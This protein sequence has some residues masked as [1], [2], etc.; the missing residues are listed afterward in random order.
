MKAHLERE[1]A[2]AARPVVKGVAYALYF[3]GV[4]AIFICLRLPV[5]AVQEATER[6]LHQ[7]LP[8]FSWR[9]A[10]VAVRL[11]LTFVLVGVEASA[12]GQDAP[13]FK[14]DRLALTPA[15]MPLFTGAY[16]LDYQAT[17]GQGTLSGTV[18]LPERSTNVVAVSGEFADML[19]SSGDRP[20]T[21]LGREVA[22]RVKGRF[23]Y[24][25]RGDAMQGVGEASVE[26]TAGGVSLAE[27]LFGITR[28]DF[29][30]AEL[31]LALQGADLAVKKGDFRSKD[32]AG[33]VSGVV[34][35]N[36][37]LPESQMR[38]DGWCELFPSF[39]A[40]L[41]LGGG[42]QDLLKQHSKDGKIPFMLH[43]AMTAPLITLK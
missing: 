41:K 21:L 27:P 11:P 37:A 12:P 31:D 4:T 14:V 32:F 13:V 17:V 40:N 36:R 25:G 9:L 38:L 3:L 22:G 16:R 26:L 35:L 42:V 23:R 2:W 24:Q 8:Q 20:L 1:S 43:G 15:I 39:F 33:E 19:L 29:D 5:S 34:T 30:H 6:A 10:S 18:G 28:V 7:G